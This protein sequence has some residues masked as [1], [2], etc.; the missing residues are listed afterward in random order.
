M[1]ADPKR[2]RRASEVPRQERAI[3]EDLGEAGV[4]SDVDDRL[5]HNH[6]LGVLLYDADGRGG[7]AAV[8]IA[9]LTSKAGLSF[10]DIRD[11]RWRRPSAGATRHRK[12]RHDIYLND[13]ASRRSRPRSSLS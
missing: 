10:H 1:A 7:E 11:V 6:D 4:R 9:V 8:R 12:P 3:Q 5:I 2:L 13:C